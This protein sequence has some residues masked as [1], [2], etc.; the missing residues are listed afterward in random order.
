ME[1]LLGKLNVKKKERVARFEYLIDNDV[2]WKQ[3]SI[4]VNNEKNNL[5]INKQYI[6][7]QNKQVT[8][9]WH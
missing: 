4:F 6:N 1:K 5:A 7:K 8:N 3:T 2:C 9:Q